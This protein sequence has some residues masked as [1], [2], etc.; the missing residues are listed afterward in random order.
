MPTRP[1]TSAST[2][3]SSKVSQTA[4][5]AIDSPSCIDPPSQDQLPLSVRS[6]RRISPASFSTT[7]LTLGTRLFGAGALGSSTQSMRVAKGPRGLDTV[8]GLA[9]DLDP[10]V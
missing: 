8:D 4:A 2:P 10:R 9:V 6:M 7:Q 5:S 3:V 1:V